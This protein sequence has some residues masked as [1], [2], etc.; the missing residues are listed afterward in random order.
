[1]ITSWP[2]WRIETEKRRLVILQYLHCAQG[3]QAAASLLRL[4]S[5]QIGVPS[6]DDQIAQ[7][8]TWLAEH[9]LIELRDAGSEIVA[10]ITRPGRDVSTGL[11]AVP[12]VLRPDP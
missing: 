4:H 5:C 11:R 1:M 10:R 3:Y 6:T 12:G 9:E 8:L 7:A 2:V